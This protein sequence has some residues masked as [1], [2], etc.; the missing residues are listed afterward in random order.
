MVVMADARERL[1]EADNKVKTAADLKMF[2]EAVLT[3]LK[4]ATDAAIGIYASLDLNGKIKGL[5]AQGV[6]EADLKAL[7]GA[8]GFHHLLANAGSIMTHHT[9][10]N[11]DNIPALMDYPML[12]APVR[13]AEKTVG[14]FLLLSTDKTNVFSQ[15]K[16]AM[17][18]QLLP[19]VARVLER[20]DLK[21]KIKSNAEEVRQTMVFLEASHDKLKKDFMN[22][23]NVFSKLIELRESKLVGHARRVADLSRTLAQRMGMNDVE[24]NDVFVAGLLH[25]I[26][27]IGL[28][29]RLLDKPFSSLT[30]EE[31]TEVVKHPIKGESVLMLLDGLQ[32]AVKYIRGHHERFDGI[33]YPDRLLGLSIPL[34][35]RILAVANDYDAAQLGTLLNKPL[36]QQEALHFIQDGRGNRY[37]PAVVDAFLGKMVKQVNAAAAVASELMLSSSQLQTGM[38][39]S[40]DMKGKDGS[41]LLSKDYIL[42]AQVIDQIKSFERMEK[43]TFTIWVI[44]SN[45]SPSKF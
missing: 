21:D 45:G 25:D 28:P 34:G 11:G 17:L 10:I 8:P 36:T 39:L 26:G 42:N 41:L 15:D 29:D 22:S 6:N 35:S 23:I 20:L 3:D 12:I 24:V 5:M 44:A 9:G 13:M 27:K 30:S 14:V 2:L 19:D 38:K 18:D 32:C 37:D 40:R 16:E 33:G 4:E 31:R 43:K 1:S 7:R